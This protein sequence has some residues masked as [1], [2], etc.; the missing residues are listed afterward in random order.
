VKHS[1]SPVFVDLR[2]AECVSLHYGFVSGHNNKK[3]QK[4]ALIFIIIEAKKLFS[5]RANKLGLSIRCLEIW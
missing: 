2:S 3:K 1:L 5:F 4:I